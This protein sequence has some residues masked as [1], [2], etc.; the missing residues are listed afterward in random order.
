M[1]SDAIAVQLRSRGHDVVAA[2]ERS[3][4]R[5]LD[6]YEIL[7]QMSTEQRVVVTE[8]AAHFVTHFGGMIARGE[9]CYGLILASNESMPRRAATVGMFVSA[10]EGELVAR[11]GVDALRDQIVWLSP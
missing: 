4:L 2:T 6:D 10:L 7:R 1:Y 9:S 5:N 8:N 3:E 11:P